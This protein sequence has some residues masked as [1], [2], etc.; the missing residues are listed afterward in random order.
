MKEFEKVSL[1]SIVSACL[2]LF[3]PMHYTDGSIAFPYMV[4]TNKMAMGAIKKKM[5]CKLLV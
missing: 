3:L 2:T 1:G 5:F 4:L